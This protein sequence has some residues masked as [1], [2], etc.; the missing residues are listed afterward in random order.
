MPIVASGQLTLVDMNDS[1][2]LVAYIGSSQ[3]RQ[4]I[5]NPNTGVYTP[6]YST[7][8]QV[9]TPQLFVAGNPTDIASSAKSIRWFY[10]TNSTGALTEITATGGSY[11][12]P[13]SGLKTLTINGNV[14]ASNTSMTYVCE[15]VYTDPDTGFD[16]VT[17]SE[18]ELVKITNG[19]NAVNALSVVLSNSAHTVPTDSAGNNGNYTGSGTTIRLFEGA[20]ELTYDGVG[21]SNGTWK[22]VASGTNITAGAISDSGLYATV[23]DASAM[24]GDTAS[25]SYTITGKRADGTAISLTATQTFSKSKQGTAGTTPTTYWLI[26][27][28]SAIQKNISGAYT[29]ATI[30]I[31]MKSQT[32]TGTPAFYGGRLIIADTTDG[33]NYT[34][35]YTSSSNE[36]GAKSYTPSAGIKALRVRMYLAGGT[37]TLLDEQIIPIVSD[38]A[39]GQNSVIGVVWTPDG[40]MIKNSSGTL[41]AQMDVYDG[42]TKVTPSAFKWYIQDPTATTASGG[43]ADGGDGWRLLNA[44]Y[45]A[46]TTG[47]ATETLTIP[48]SAI[49]NVESF[50]CVATYGS[51]KYTDVCT[52][53]DVTDPIVVTII[54][55]NTFKNGTGTTTLKA[56]LYR[57]GVEIDS[58]GT[59]YTYTWSL[60]NQDGTKNNTALGGD[61]VATGKTIIVDSADVNVR[62]NIICE[63][64]K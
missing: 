35:R 51:K 14:L 49:A 4:V 53:T 63:V 3:Q 21:T 58:A 7:S 11:V 48:A 15:M 62:A 30:S 50:K 43:D 44:T 5:Y 59:E 10:Q 2:Q 9:L 31:D 32:G 61:G 41:K 8:N 36:T 27:S 29:P 1:K 42:T 57:N 56:V 22:V 18:I 20:T 25:I 46:G 34:D 60:Y 28:A 52:V 12:L 45:N 17:K 39:T 19:T 38:G 33:T 16:I 6:N 23:A 26:P 54:G 37:T 40:N 24:T 13:A 55:I 47:Y 64:S